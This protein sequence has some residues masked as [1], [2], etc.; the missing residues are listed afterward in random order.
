MINA[1][2]TNE[3]LSINLMDAINFIHMEWQ[4]KGNEFDLVDDLPLIEWLKKNQEVNDNDEEDEFGQ[5]DFDFNEYVYVDGNL[6]RV[7]FLSDDDAFYC[8]CGKA[9]CG[10]LVQSFIF[11]LPKTMDWTLNESIGVMQSLENT[12]GAVSKIAFNQL[13]ELFSKNVGYQTLKCS[14]D[15]LL[16]SDITNTFV[17]T[18]YFLNN[19]VFFDSLTQMSKEKRKLIVHKWCSK[20]GLSSRQLAKSMDVSVNGAKK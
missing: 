1:I 12:P 7:E 16:G 17:T 2:H 10:I 15:V 20:H 6:V 9:N 3:N 4:K 5:V 18:C 11:I 13:E 19:F 14:N 8:V